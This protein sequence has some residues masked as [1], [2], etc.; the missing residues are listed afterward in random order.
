[1]G[2]G[3]AHGL[4]PPHAMAPHPAPPAPRQPRQPSAAAKQR[5]A[6]G[7]ASA[8]AIKAMWRRGKWTPEEE[9][10]VLLLGGVIVG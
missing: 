5:A 1:M 8:A 2:M 7:G 3:G 4:L 6:D 9:V 10:G